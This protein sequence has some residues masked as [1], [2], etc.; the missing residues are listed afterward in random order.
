M[1]LLFRDLRDAVGRRIGRTVVAQHVG[2]DVTVGAVGI[3]VVDGRGGHDQYRLGIRKSMHQQR[4]A[5]GV[6]GHRVVI[7]GVERLE[8]REM[9]H[10]VEAIGQL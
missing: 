6:D 7:A 1:R 10:V 3:V 9:Q 8:D 4:R 2:L 5:L